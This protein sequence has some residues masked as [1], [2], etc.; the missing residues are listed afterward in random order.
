MTSSTIEMIECH[1][2]EK[3][4]SH[5]SLLDTNAGSQVDGYLCGAGFAYERYDISTLSPQNYAGLKAAL[6]SGSHS[7][8]LL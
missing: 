8:T 5:S 2:N 6:D 7:M 3:L 1:V 4:V